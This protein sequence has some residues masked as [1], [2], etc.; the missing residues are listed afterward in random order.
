MSQREQ[1]VQIEALLRRVREPV[2]LRLQIPDLL[3]GHKAEV[4]V[5]D[6]GLGHGRQAAVNGKPRL[7]RNRLVKGV[8]CFGHP[9]QDHAA[10]RVGC[11]T[12]EPFDFRCKRERLPARPHDQHGRGVGRAREV[13][14][15]GR[16]RGAGNAVVKAHH[17]L[18]DAQPARRDVPRELAAHLGFVHKEQ[19]EVS[20]RDAE[21]RGMEHGIDV[22]RAALERRKRRAAPLERAQQRACHGGLAAARAGARDQQAGRVILHL[23]RLPTG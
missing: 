10:Q 9:V 21:H 13:R 12:P 19:V 11:E 7:L 6:L 16:V 22:I 23:L 2:E 14:G 15:R 8:H 3:R 18:D 5:G 17:T 4:P 1:T 20:A